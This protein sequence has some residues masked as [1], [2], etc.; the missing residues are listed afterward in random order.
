MSGTVDRG[1]KNPKLTEAGRKYMAERTPEEIYDGEIA[2]IL[3]SLNV[4]LT[5]IDEAYSALEAL[6]IRRA[7]GQD[8][9]YSRI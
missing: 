9:Q 1:Y 5:A 4:A 6:K 7:R 8:G 3:S 2:C